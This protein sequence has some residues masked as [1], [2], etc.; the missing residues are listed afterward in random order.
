MDKCRICG[1]L[2]FSFRAHKCKP[3]WMVRGEDDLEEDA[4]EIRASDAQEAA[5][6]Y[7]AYNDA[8]VAEFTEE[9]IV[10]VRGIPR[11]SRGPG[12]QARAGEADRWC[13]EP[14][15]GRVLGGSGER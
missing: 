11:R 10:I 15:R 13:G 5:E 7:A 9:Q 6:K 14:T 4:I 1:E 3:V 12:E 8:C 2:Y